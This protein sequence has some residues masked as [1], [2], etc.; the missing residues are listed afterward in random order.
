VVPKAALFVNT[1]PDLNGEMIPN[2][3]FIGGN[4]NWTNFNEYEK[5]SFLVTLIQFLHRGLA[6][7]I[8]AYAIWIFYKHVIGQNL[9]RNIKTSYYAFMFFLALQVLVGIVTLVNSISSIPVSWGVLHQAIAV[10][11][12]A[13]FV[14]HFFHQGWSTVTSKDQIL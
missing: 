9:E 10:L 7:L 8:T 2:Q 6:Y 11:V 3:I 5:S 4:W 1:W 14:L 12:L 13:T